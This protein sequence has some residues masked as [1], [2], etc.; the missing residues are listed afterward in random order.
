MK[1]G[2][3]T[4][5]YF[6]GI[7]R[8]RTRINSINNHSITYRMYTDKRI[9]SGLI[10][11]ATSA[12]ILDCAQIL[13]T[14]MGGNIPQEWRMLP[15]EWNRN[16]VYWRKTLPGNG[17][18]E[19]SRNGILAREQ[20]LQVKPINSLSGITV[21]SRRVT[22]ANPNKEEDGSSHETWIYTSQTSLSSPHTL[23]TTHT[24]N[25][26]ALLKDTI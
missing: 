6:T 13:F 16:T 14:G 11:H 1:Y 5:L 9:S 4:A 20:H 7:F 23:S 10:V 25:T 3:N 24:H 21:F 22:S 17:T 8:V 19:H 12:G 18:W 2:L 26:R 15:R